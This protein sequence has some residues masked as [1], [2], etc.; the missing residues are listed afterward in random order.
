M[1]RLYTNANF[2]VSVRKWANSVGM[3]VYCTSESWKVLVV[4]KA[5]RGRNLYIFHLYSNAFPLKCGFG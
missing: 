4:E 1:M 2:P 3:L 5:R